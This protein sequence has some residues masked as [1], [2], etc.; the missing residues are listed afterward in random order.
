MAGE[1]R[2]PRKRNG[3][4]ANDHWPY[5]WY[6]VRGIS[7]AGLPRFTL[8]GLRAAATSATRETGG[9]RWSRS[10]RGADPFADAVACREVNDAD[11]NAPP[12]GLQGLL[13]APVRGSGADDGTLS[14]HGNGAPS[15][16]EMNP[17]GAAVVRPEA[18]ATSLP[19]SLRSAERLVAGTAHE[20]RPG[21]R[22]GR[23][24]GDRSQPAPVVSLTSRRRIGS[25]EKAPFPGLFL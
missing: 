7:P 11:A 13:A 25:I 15:G 18:H 2:R 8:S 3:V 14:V 21:D 17:H 24:H 4:S 6:P 20:A 16:K 19:V 23:F 10:G 1:G 5:R 22:A 12:F 9:N